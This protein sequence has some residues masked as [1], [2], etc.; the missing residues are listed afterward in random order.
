[1]NWNFCYIF[2]RNNEKYDGIIENE[3]GLRLVVVIIEERG[4]FIVDCLVK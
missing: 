4:F 1:M 2:C 3:L